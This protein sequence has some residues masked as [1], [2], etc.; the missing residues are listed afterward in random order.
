MQ[1]RL[2]FRFY[3][4]N[5]KKIFDVTQIDLS[6]NLIMCSTDLG[7]E[8][9]HLSEGELMQCIGLKDKNEKLIYE[10]D[11]IDVT[12]YGAQIP[13]FLNKYSKIPKNERFA[14]I[15]DD[16]WHKFR[17]ENPKYRSICE[18][19]SLDIDKIQINTENKTYEIIGNIYENPERLESEE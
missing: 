6:L 11:I 17:C 13:L 1:E 2:K 7:L 14:I 18:I 3:H 16:N 15:Y 9:F 12:Y 8:E 4:K 19:H 10:G 5:Y